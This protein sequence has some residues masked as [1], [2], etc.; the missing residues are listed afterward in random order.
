MRSR[1]TKPSDRTTAGNDNV[2]A[3]LG[4]PASDEMLV[5]AELMRQVNLLIEA[6]NL[7]Q[8]QAARL[9]GV[10]QPNVSALKR[11]RLSDFSLDRLIR[12]LVALGQ[13]VNIRVRPAPARAG[14]KVARRRAS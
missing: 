2:F 7:T 14:I 10:A 1:E 4:L 12:F 8:A 3:D 5:R 9:L 13:E 6:Q 11:G